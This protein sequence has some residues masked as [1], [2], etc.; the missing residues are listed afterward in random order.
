QASEAGGVARKVM[1]ARIAGVSRKAT[2]ESPLVTT[3]PDEP[4]IDGKGN[5]PK[6]VP[7]FALMVATPGT[8]SP[9]I[10]IAAFGGFCQTLFT[11]VGK[12]VCT[13]PDVPPATL[14]PCRTCAIVCNESV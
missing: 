9:S 4:L 14:L 6:S 11:E 5:S 3:L 10:T 8:K 12:S 2:I 7:G 1:N 13:A